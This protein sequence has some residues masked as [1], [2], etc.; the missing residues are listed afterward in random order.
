MGDRRIVAAQ[1]E[2][3]K[4]MEEKFRSTSKQSIDWHSS[5][6]V[7]GGSHSLVIFLAFIAQL[8]RQHQL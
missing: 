4:T 7:K 6:V 8:Q 2:L 3:S 1:M 5:V